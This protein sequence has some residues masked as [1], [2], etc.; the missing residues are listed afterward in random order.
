MSLVLL[1]LA[2]KLPKVIEGRLKAGE[3]QSPMVP[4]S[5][6][7][8]LSACKSLVQILRAPS[9]S[10]HKADRSFTPRFPNAFLN[11]PLGG[12]CWCTRTVPLLILV[13]SMWVDI[14][15]LVL[16]GL[17]LARCKSRGA[18]GESLESSFFYHHSSTQHK[19]LRPKALHNHAL[20]LGIRYIGECGGGRRTGGHDAATV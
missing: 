6:G 10:A 11:G 19:N 18:D 1:H 8:P 5:N 14:G 4:L 7:K 9:R 3:G 12:L 15:M 20:V 16:V 2:D 17:R 13:L